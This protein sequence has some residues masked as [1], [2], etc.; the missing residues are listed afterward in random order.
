MLFRHLS[1]LFVAY[2]FARPVETD[3]RRDNLTLVFLIPADKRESVGNATS[4]AIVVAL[5]DLRE[6]N[7]TASR[8]R[9]ADVDWE[10]RNSRHAPSAAVSN[11]MQIRKSVGRRRIGAVFGGYSD[12]TCETLRL[13]SVALGVPFFGIRC[14]FGGEKKDQSLP[15]KSSGG[16]NITAVGMLFCPWSL[17]PLIVGLLRYFN[18]NR[19]AI[20]ATSDPHA[21]SLGS[22]LRSILASRDTDA[23]LFICTITTIDGNPTSTGDVEDLM[24]LMTQI[25]T[26]ARGI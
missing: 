19:V 13:L 17:N 23:F 25:K 3:Q 4:S 14:H 5:N 21:L 18:W 9:Y 24:R 11:L 16:P 15:V 1:C 7:L 8:Q 2:T 22:N 12:E 10:L 20:L 26:Y 6:Y